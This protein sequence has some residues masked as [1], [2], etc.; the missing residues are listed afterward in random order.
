MKTLLCL[1]IAMFLSIPAHVYAQEPGSGGGPLGIAP[2]ILEKEPAGWQTPEEAEQAEVKRMNWFEKQMKI[3][4]L[5]E[6]KSAFHGKS[7][8]S[9]QKRMKDQVEWNKN[10][11][12]QRF[13]EVVK[14]VEEIGYTV[15]SYGEHLILQKDD[16]YIRYFDGRPTDIFNQL[17]RDNYGNYHNVNIMNI[18]FLDSDQFVVNYTNTTSTHIMEYIKLD[19]DSVGAINYVK[20][21]DAAYSSNITD[22]PSAYTTTTGA[23]EKTPAMELYVPDNT[24][25]AKDLYEKI[26]TQVIPTVEDLLTYTVQT[27]FSNISYYSLAQDNATGTVPGGVYGEKDSYDYTLTS[28][29]A[30]DAPETGTVNNIQYYLLDKIHVAPM[31]E[32]WWHAQDATLINLHHYQEPREAGSHTI[33]TRMGVTQE[34]DFYD[35][36]YETVHN[37]LTGYR[38]TYKI[39]G[40]ETGRFYYHDIGHDQ[41][42]RQA[43]YTVEDNTY[44]QGYRRDYSGI[45]YDTLS[46]ITGYTMVETLEGTST[47]YIYWN[48][49]YNNLWQLTD[50][51]YSINGVEH[52]RFDTTYNSYG[53]ITSY[54]DVSI[55]NGITTTIYRYNTYNSNGLLSEY[56]QYELHQGNGITE[57][58]YIWAGNITYN[59]IYAISMF[60]QVTIKDT[61]ATT[62]SDYA[63]KIPAIVNALVFDGTTYV[64]NPLDLAAMGFNN[65]TTV[66]TDKWRGLDYFGVTESSAGSNYYTFSLGSFRGKLKNYSEALRT[67]TTSSDK[68]EMH[69]LQN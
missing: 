60:D 22:R 49:T 25:E 56:T 5:A 13:L 50:Y 52:H 53:L 21:D 39:N 58:Y 11:T 57:F 68:T 28:T 17:E 2:F 6:K 16:S 18:A 33:S 8:A 38:E 44:G 66:Y 35:A 29:D 47:T 10:Y 7:I 36:Q 64:L 43:S 48:M 15:A 46:R 23:A 55:D 20:F 42:G 45:T 31:D 30:Q 1:S 59:S 27:A 34:I 41:Y 14:Q 61:N 32:Y 54:T 69:T 9:I 26:I 67:T 63:S 40:T 19:Y 65:T 51:Y 4:S 12:L 37:S 3:H 24:K 62:I